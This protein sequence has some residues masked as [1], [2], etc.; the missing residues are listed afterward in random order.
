MSARHGPDTAGRRAIT[1]RDSGPGVAEAGR[2]ALFSPFRQGAREAH[3]RPAGAGARLAL[4]R[5][6]VERMGGG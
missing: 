4:A 5:R 3:T 2:E 1:V 6:L